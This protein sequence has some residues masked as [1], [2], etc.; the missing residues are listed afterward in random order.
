MHILDLHDQHLADVVAEL[1]TLDH[2]ESWQVKQNRSSVVHEPY[3]VNATPS[4][5]T[6]K[7]RFVLSSWAVSRA[8]SSVH[9]GLVAD[10]DSAAIHIPTPS[11]TSTVWRRRR[12]PYRAW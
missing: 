9:P 7:D 11:P 8:T 4:P 1:D 3:G 5:R 10:G 12:T 2:D 6:V